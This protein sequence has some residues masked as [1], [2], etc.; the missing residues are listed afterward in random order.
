MKTKE[1]INLLN[2]CDATGEKEV[3][4]SNQ[5]IDY[6][7]KEP[8]YYSNKGYVITKRE[9]YKQNQPKEITI[10]LSDEKINLIP[11]NTFD[12]YKKKIIEDQEFISIKTENNVF[13]WESAK[14]FF[15][16]LC[17]LFY[18]KE[19]M[20]L[21]D[22]ELYPYKDNLIKKI[23]E[24]IINIKEE[25]KKNYLNHCEKINCNSK[26]KTKFLE[27]I[28]RIFDSNMNVVFNLPLVDDD[29]ITIKTVGF[30]NFKFETFESLYIYSYKDIYDKD[31]YDATNIN[32]ESFNFKKTIGSL[33]ESLLNNKIEKLLF[34]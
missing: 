17:S 32:L 20:T 2:Q 15:N 5:D 11:L 4:I 7:V 28:Y 1:L 3:L 14:L 22:K 21:S 6:I 26:L 23:D 9:D 31:I 10:S 12:Y 24:N 29:K 33:W 13:Y 8:M 25:Y 18:C 19:Y 27:L 16:K 34:D 30:K